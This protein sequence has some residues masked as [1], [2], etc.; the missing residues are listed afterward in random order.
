MTLAKSYSTASLSRA[1]VDFMVNELQLETFM[2][3]IEWRDQGSDEMFMG[4]LNTADA[5]T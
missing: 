5:L 2:K 3:A 4:S 1:A